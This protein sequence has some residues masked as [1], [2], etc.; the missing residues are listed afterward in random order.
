MTT[1]A[2]Y[3]GPRTANSEHEYHHT[4]YDVLRRLIELAPFTVL[5]EREEALEVVEQARAMGLFG[6]TADNLRSER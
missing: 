1:G 4:I 3:A 2:G 5:K 6:T